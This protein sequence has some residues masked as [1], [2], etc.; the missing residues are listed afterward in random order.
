MTRHF[1]VAWATIAEQ[2][3]TAIL[4][5]VARGSPAGATKLLLRLEQRASSLETLPLRGRIV[6]ELLK[7]QVR[8][9][10]ELLIGPYRLV[11]RVESAR[12]VVLGVFD[13]RRNLEDILLDRLIGA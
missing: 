3:L 11:Y 5:F 12:V 2:D 8:E 1:T 10:R 7:I 13:G 9:Y 4:D 6:P